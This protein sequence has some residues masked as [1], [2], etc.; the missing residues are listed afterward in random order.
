VTVEHVVTLVNIALGT[1]S[2][3]QCSSGDAD[4]DNT[5]TIDEIVT[6]VNAALDGCGG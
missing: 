4:H 6:A 1:T 3:A 2:V 5:I